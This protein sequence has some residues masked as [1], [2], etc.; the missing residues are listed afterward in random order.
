MADLTPKPGAPVPELPPLPP[1]LRIL[2]GSPAD[3]AIWHLLTARY[4]GEEDY[5]AVAQ[6]AYT[7]L[8]ERRRVVWAEVRAHHAKISHTPLLALPDYEGAA[9]TTLLGICTE[10]S[11]VLRDHAMACSN[12]LDGVGRWPSPLPPELLSQICGRLVAA[13]IHL[14]AVRLEGGAVPDETPNDRRTV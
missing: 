9:L 13:E 11:K 1:A 10:W 2:P 7:R 12:Y 6:V 3:A 4:E 5:A 14:A 8:E